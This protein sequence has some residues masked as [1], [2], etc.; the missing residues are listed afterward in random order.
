M[1]SVVA[2]NALAELWQ[3]GGGASAALDTIRLT[4]SDPVLPSSFAVGAL[5]QATI[6]AAG[7]AAVELWHLKTGRRQTVTV[8]M[9]HAAAEF[10][11]ERLFKVATEPPHLWDKIAG[12]YRTRDGGWVRI[13]TNF[14]HHRDGILSLLGAPYDRDAVQAALLQWNGEDF[15][16]AAAARNL[17]A[18]LTRSPEQWTAHPQGQAVAALPIFEIIRIGDA[19]PQPLPTG[20]RPLS[21]IRVLD[22]TRIIAGP[23]GGR[24]LA[25]HGADV[26][27]ITSPNLPTIPSLVID[28][29]RGKRS[30][31][32]DLN[33]TTARATLS[34]LV[35][36]AD[37]FIQGYRPG[38]IA[39]RGFAP[40]QLASLRPGIVAVSLSAY[41]HTGPWA[42]RRGFDSLTQ[43]TNGINVAEAKAAGQ[44]KP[45]ELPAQ[46]LDHGAGYLIATGAMLALHRRATE[47]G[48]WHVRISLAQVGEWLKRL[49]SVTNGHA[50]PDPTV[51]DFADLLETSDSGF[52]PMTAVRHAGILSETP[53]HW[54]R[55]SVPLGTHAAAWLART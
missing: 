43:N 47:G 49:P 37:V 31:S 16:S 23:V 13:H 53:A 26:L 42:T 38:G 11:S 30:A 27:A 36:N 19:A 48:S 29:G 32:L 34:A 12:L 14:P 10:R 46:A 17:V 33:D 7:L 35:R 1:A 40:E 21:G 55:P 54:A 6:A 3:L 45:K 9:R 28:T 22:L 24:T 51:A 52:G 39:A 25:A 18:T 41:G 20:T 2:R 15:E 8:D 4:G 50:V 5:A 44:D